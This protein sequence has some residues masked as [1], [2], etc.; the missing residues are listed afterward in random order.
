MKKT[1]AIILGCAAALSSFAGTEAFQASLTPDIAVQDKD[2][3][4]EG[5]ALSI[6][7]ENEQKAFALG[8]VNGSTGDSS[9]LSLGIVKLFRKLHRRGMGIC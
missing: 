6:W 2:T 1:L 4:I 9:G 3:R 8:F 5:I 7:G